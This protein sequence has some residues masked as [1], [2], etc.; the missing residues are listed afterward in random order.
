MGELY[1]ARAT[2]PEELPRVDSTGD[3][4]FDPDDIH[5]DTGLGR[6]VVPFGQEPYPE[7]GAGWRRFRCCATSCR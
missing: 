5:F 4:G 6:L 3:A 1:R 7:A 2:A